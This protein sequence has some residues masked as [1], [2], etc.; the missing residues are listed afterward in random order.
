[1]A[2]KRDEYEE[3]RCLLNTTDPADEQAKVLA[4]NPGIAARW[5]DACGDRQIL[6]V[7]IGRNMDRAA[8][9]ASLDACLSDWTPA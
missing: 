4:E 1:M 7:F 2:L 6:L 9:E 5:D 8:I 3:K